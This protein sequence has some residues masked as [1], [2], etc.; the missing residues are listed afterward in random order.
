MPTVPVR[1]LNHVEIRVENYHD[2]ETVLFCIMACF[3][4]I[5]LVGSGIW[6]LLAAR[7]V[8]EERKVIALTLDDHDEEEKREKKKGSRSDAGSDVSSCE[9]EVEKE[10]EQAGAGAGAGSHLSTLAKSFM[11]WK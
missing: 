4:F 1:S 2:S 5:G 8:H 6:C 10:N 7:N 9:I 11:F 3:V